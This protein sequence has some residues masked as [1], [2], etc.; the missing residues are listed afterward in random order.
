MRPLKDRGNACSAAEIDR[1]PVLKALICRDVEVH[2]HLPLDLS[3]AI[4][5]FLGGELRTYYVPSGVGRTDSLRAAVLAMYRSPASI[6]CAGAHDR[7][8]H[9]ASR[10]S[11]ICHSNIESLS[12]T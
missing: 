3:S 6:C 11:D 12:F 9:L 2:P 7:N 1:Q 4:A 10:W 5:T 8:L